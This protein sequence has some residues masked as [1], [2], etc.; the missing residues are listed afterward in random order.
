M[1]NM[2]KFGE[3]N[4]FVVYFTEFTIYLYFMNVI[5]SQYWVKECFSILFLFFLLAE[6]VKTRNKGKGKVQV[7]A[8][9]D[10]EDGKGF[11]YS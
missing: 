1:V 7:N 11:H 3:D 6:E 2:Q 9:Q 5:V 8:S 10:S 4:F